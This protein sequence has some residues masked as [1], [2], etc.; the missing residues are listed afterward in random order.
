MTRG[1]PGDPGSFPKRV[2]LEL[3]NQCNLNCTFCPRRYMEKERGFLDFGLAQELIREMADHAPV[4]VVPF[5]R[6]ESLLHPQWYESLKLIQELQV[7]EIQFTTNASLLDRKKSERVLDLGLSFISF[8]LDTLDPALYESSRRGSDYHLVMN[9]V[10]DFL[11]LRDKL[12]VPTRVQVS[13][14]ETDLH[15]PGMDAFVEFWRDKVDRVRIY[16]EHSS[17]GHPGSIDEPLPEFEERLPCHKPF[18]DMVVYWNGQTACC[19][20]DWTRLVDGT[21]LGNV[22]ELGIANVWRGE[23]YA[24]LREAHRCGAF[25]G[26]TPCVGCDHWKMYYMNAGYLGRT[27]DKRG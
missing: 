11:E 13:A 21:P 1:L 24:R 6:G 7:G 3:T 15:R 16:A 5:F 8:S 17:D 20:H 10:L 27:Y 2:T 26:V 22:A 19:N 23:A 4:T 18:T 14:V 25:D 12:G 9:N